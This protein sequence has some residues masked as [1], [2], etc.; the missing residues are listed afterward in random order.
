MSHFLLVAYLALSIFSTR[1]FA[2]EAT[3]EAKFSASFPKTPIVTITPIGNGELYEVI[4]ESGEILY[5]THTGNFLLTSNGEVWGIADLQPTNITEQR[6]IS[7]VI[8]V[9]ESDTITFRSPN[10]I[11]SIS[12]FTDVDCEYCRKLHKDIP[13]LNAKGVT[14]RYLAYPRGGERG[15]SFKKMKSIWCSPDRAKAFSTAVNGVILPRQSECLNPV[16]ESFQLGQ[17][18]KVEGTP[19]IVAPNRII[20]GYIS[21]EYLLNQILDN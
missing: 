17:R 9:P 1:S 5:S 16:L 3:I 19:T 12:V 2:D 15:L 21:S 13:L 7:A 10:E 6:S 8:K 14:V 20:T 11:T 4:L 18:I